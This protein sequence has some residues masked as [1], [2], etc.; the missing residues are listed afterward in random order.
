MKGGKKPAVVGVKR[1]ME[2]KHSD[3]GELEL[4]FR[5]GCWAGGQGLGAGGLGG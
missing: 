4:E 2:A 1:S 5:V 3:G